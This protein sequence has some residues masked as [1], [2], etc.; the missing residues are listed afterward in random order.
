MVVKKR[1]KRRYIYKSVAVKIEGS[2]NYKNVSF[3]KKCITETGKINSGRMLEVNAI[4][5]RAISKSI[6]IARYL[7]LLPYCDSHR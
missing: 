4:Q 7:A 2:L 1:K 3:L 5:Q 6:K